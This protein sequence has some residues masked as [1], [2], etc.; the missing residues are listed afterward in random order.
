MVDSWH[1]QDE[2]ERFEH[3]ACP[4]RLDLEKLPVGDR[5][6]VDRVIGRRDVVPDEERVGDR[7]FAGDAPPNKRLRV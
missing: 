6:T 5:V 7:T 4:C 1:V 3:R 2:L